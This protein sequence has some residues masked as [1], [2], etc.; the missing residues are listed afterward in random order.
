MED[1]IATLG[2]TTDPTTPAPGPRNALERWFAPKLRDPRD[3]VFVRTAAELTWKLAI[4]GALFFAGVLPLWLAPVWWVWATAR[5]LARYTLMLHATCHRPLFTRDHPVWNG[6][7]TWVIGPFLGHT[8]NSFYVHHMGMHHPEN[9]LG[10]DLSSTLAYRRDSLGHFVH[11]WARFFFVGQVHLVRYL[12]HRRRT[13]LVKRFVRGEVAW[14]STMALL[15]WLA[16]GPTFVVFLMPF[17]VVRYL[18]MAG[19]WSQHAFVDVDDP[20]NAYKN[21]TCLINTPYNQMCFNDGYHIVHHIKPSLHY[22][23]MATWMYDHIE[24]FGRQDAIVFDGLENNQT[25]W[26]YLM[27]RNYDA[28]AEHMVDLPCAPERTH[29]EKVAFLKDRVQRQVGTVR[30]LV[31]LAPHPKALA[32][33]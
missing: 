8:P 26:W 6:F 33:K 23:E 15:T 2:P 17:L 19:N 27:T 1:A 20:G 22:T 21:S 32:A 30:K 18:M 5:Y 10:E 12:W 3:I 7:I 13:R 9:N 4:P 28:L 25:V 11:Y 31:E 24:E 14:F 29:D 16:P